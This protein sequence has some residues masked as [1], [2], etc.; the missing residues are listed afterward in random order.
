[1]RIFDRGCGCGCESYCLMMKLCSY[2]IRGFGGSSKKKEVSQIVRAN[3]LDM[4][5]IQETKAEV[6]YHR[7]CALMW[8]DDDF[9][10]CFNLSSSRAWGLVIIW[11]NGSFTLEE[12][13]SGESFLGV[14]GWWGLERIIISVINVYAPCDSQK[15][16]ELWQQISNVM[17]LKGVIYGVSWG[18]STQCYLSVKGKSEHR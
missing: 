4:I 9:S 6:V 16:L 13:F 11:R 3:K 8:D 18:I 1:M 2:N 15:K 14:T 12:S 10:M 17:I 5:C 7:M